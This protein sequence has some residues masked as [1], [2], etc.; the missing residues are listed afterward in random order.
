MARGRPFHNELEYTVNAGI[1][2]QQH[3]ILR[4]TLGLDRGVD[5]NHYVDETCATNC[6]VLVHKGMM[7]L[8]K[9]A[10]LKGSKAGYIFYH[11]TNFGREIAVRE[12]SE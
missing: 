11:A 6:M 5:R 9:D 3:T 10:K 4:H 1:T 7:I 8:G 2:E 12:W